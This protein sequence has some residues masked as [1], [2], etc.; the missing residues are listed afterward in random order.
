MRYEELRTPA[1]LINYEQF[2]KNCEKMALKADALDLDFWPHVKT[3]KTIK[4]AEIQRNGRL[5]GITVSTL[6]EAWYYAENGFDRITYAFPISADKLPEIH[7][8]LQITEEFRLVTDNEKI[9]SDL[10]HYGKLHE[11]NFTVFLKIDTGSHRAGIAADDP[12]LVR[13]AQ[14]IHESPVLEFAGLLSHAGH[15]YGSKSRDEIIERSRL[16]TE[17]LNKALAR[18]KESGIPV[19]SVS[20]GDTPACVVAESF[21]PATELRPGNYT[22]FDRMQVDLGTCEEQDVAGFVL[23]RIIGAYPDRNT[24][25]IDA[26]A[27][28]LSKDLGGTH[29]RNDGTYGLIMENPDLKLSRISQEHGVITCESPIDFETFTL[30]S[31]LTIMPNHSCLTAAL[32]ERFFV[33]DNMKNRKL[34]DSWKPIRGW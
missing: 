5:C 10:E 20:I 22:F 2:K 4:G 9:I 1:F 25:L 3:H 26:G 31:F 11:L 27:L 14:K 7:E 23:T 30:G 33:V 29:L 12:N 17:A 13:L 18:L 21:G 8:L 32:H 15:T 34:L 16:E 28:A 6:A 24:L 19:E